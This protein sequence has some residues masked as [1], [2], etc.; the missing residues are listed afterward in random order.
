MEDTECILCIGS[1]C[2]NREVNIAKALLWLSEILLDFRHSHIYASPDTTGGQREYLNAVCLGKTFLT[3][4][5]LDR[6]C[7]E[8]E[9]SN[10]RDA[11]A[12]ALGDVPVD[13]DVVEY[14]HRILRARD[15]GSEY[16]RKGY[17]E[18]TNKASPLY[19]GG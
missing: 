12:R 10:G 18:L 15:Y 8:Y 1:N 13:I 7:K 9:K 3:A 11:R 2:G 17:E 16:F 19:V 5:A 4:E 6:L 14:G